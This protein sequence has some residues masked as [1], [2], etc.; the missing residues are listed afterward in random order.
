MGNVNSG[1]H[2]D[3]TALAMYRDN[4]NY[5]VHPLSICISNVCR[6]KNS[7]TYHAPVCTSR[8]GRPQAVVLSSTPSR[9]ESSSSSSAERFKPSNYTA[10]FLHSS[11]SV[12]AIPTLGSPWGWNSLHC[13]V[14]VS[15]AIFSGP[16]TS[17]CAVVHLGHSSSLLYV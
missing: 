1:A 8:V 14:S 12:I 16:C 10:F 13:H 5:I 6:V 4:V 15:P 9:G 7:G 17:H 3:P 2:L 11:S